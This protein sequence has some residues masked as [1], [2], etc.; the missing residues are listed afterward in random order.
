MLTGDLEQRAGAAPADRIWGGPYRRLTF[1]LLLIITS[2]AYEA[3]AVATVMPDTAAELGGLGLY[4]WS[5]SAFMLANLFGTVVAG[6]SID[7]HGAAAPFL[8]GSGLFVAGLLVAGLAPSMALLIA[9]R[10]V[11]GLG[12]GFI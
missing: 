3:L 10:A 7:R 2:A 5:F 1:G 8:A 12:A 4:G 11:Q 6:W 9:G